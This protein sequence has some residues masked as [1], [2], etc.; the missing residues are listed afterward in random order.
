MKTITHF[1]G[2]QPNP[3]FDHP[4][5]ERLLQGNPHRTTWNHYENPVTGTSSGIWACEPGAWR[6][7]FADRKDEFFTVI[8]GRI[9]LTD[10]AGHAVE[11]GPGE[12]AVI[13]AGFRGVF[14]VLETVR[15]YYVVVEA[16]S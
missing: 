12:A 16:N 15:K 10:E 6:I 14:E 9:R 8:E 7:E 2:Q 4:R 5:P 3:V 11:V 1:Q 13:P